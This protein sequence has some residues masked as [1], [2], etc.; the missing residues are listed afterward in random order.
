[1]FT[2]MDR[3]RDQYSPKE[4]IYNDTLMYKKY[5]LYTIFILLLLGIVYWNYFG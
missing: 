3:Y 5:V 2:A 4:F 1:M